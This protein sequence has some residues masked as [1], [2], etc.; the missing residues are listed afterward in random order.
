MTVG[1]VYTSTWNI[2]KQRMGLFVGLSAIAIS[3]SFLA[4]FLAMIPMIGM[5]VASINRLDPSSMFSAIGIGFVFLFIAAVFASL[6]T[7]KVTGM[8]S[9]ATYEIVQGRNPTIGNLWAQ[10]KGY[11]P[12]IVPFFLALFGGIFVLELVL[13]L[14]L[15]SVAGS[16]STAAAVGS[17]VMSLIVFVGGLFLGTRWAYVVPSSSIEGTNGF[18]AAKKSWKLT[19][20]EFWRTLGVILAGMAPAFVFMLLMVGLGSVG[21]T[22]YSTAGPLS[23]IAFA[24]ELAFGLF[25]MPFYTIYVV[26]MFLDQLRR[27]GTGPNAQDAWGGA[28]QWGAQQQFYTGSAYGTPPPAAPWQTPAPPQQQP[29]Q[30]TASAAPQGQPWQSPSAPQAQPP[31]PSAPTEQ[32]PAAQP[33]QTPQAPV[34]PQPVNQPWLPAGPGVQT[35]A[36]PTWT[37]QTPPVPQPWQQQPPTDPAQNWQVPSQPQN[38]TQPQYPWNQQGQ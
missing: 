18:D 22:A 25:W 7:A 26:V 29:W 38:P 4:M 27:N 5:M 32:A 24:L 33:W 11:L 8:M 35:P 34:T 3:I 31:W 21:R 10:T 17:I 20:P 15:G 28:P 37:P 19:G 30:D 1:A 16:G 14:I 23:S 12:R 13:A 36:T 9:L 6:V 2:F